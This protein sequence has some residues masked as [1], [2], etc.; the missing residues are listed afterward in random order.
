M[1]PE[2][3]RVGAT[4][5][6]KPTLLRRG[7]SSLMGVGRARIVATTM[8]PCPG[9]SCILDASSSVKRV[10]TTAARAA[11]VANGDDGDN[12]GVE[13]EQSLE[14][15][16]LGVFGKILGDLPVSGIVGAKTHRELGK[17]GGRARG[18]EVGRFV[19]RG[20]R[21]GDIPQPAD[22]MGLLV[23]MGADPHPLQVPWPRRAQKAPPR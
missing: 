21:V 10:I 23:P 19:Q 9:S 1:L 11:V 8:G 17:L 6:T 5:A 22:P 12:T 3:A 20:A 18:D 2:E 16:L 13:I 15:E 7:E 14:G 4:A